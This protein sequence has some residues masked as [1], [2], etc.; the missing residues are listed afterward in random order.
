MDARLILMLLLACLCG[1]G[2]RQNPHMNVHVEMLNA[3]KRAL[4]DQIYALQYDYDAKEAEVQRLMD[5]VDRLRNRAG[6]ATGEEIQDDSEFTPPSIELPDESEEIPD[7]APPKVE[8]G[9][10]E[11]DP[12]D[13]MLPTLTLDA[14][15]EPTALDPPDP[16]VDHIAINREAT[17]GIDLDEYPGDDGIQVV[18]EPRNPDGDF[19]PLAGPVS[20]VLLDAA[21]PQGEQ[22]RVARWDLEASEVDGLIRDSESERGIY[23]TL[24]WPQRAP[25][26]RHLHLFLRYETVDGRRHQAEQVVSIQPSAQVTRDSWTPRPK[27]QPDAASDAHRIRIARPEWSPYR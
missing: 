8:P 10:P 24:P 4:E 21:E 15:R 6:S 17:R 7:L 9:T 1:G 13:F 20:V 2:C 25:R 23:L 18:F 5:E 14:S 3:E 16:H 19:V 27:E 26:H 11:E 22:Q 12:G